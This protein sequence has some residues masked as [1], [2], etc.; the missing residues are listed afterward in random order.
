MAI[1]R[2][3]KRFFALISL[4]LLVLAANAL[5]YRSPLSSII[6]PAEAHWVVTGSLIDLVIVV[7]LLVLALSR[8]KKI[9]AR[10][11][12]PLM[13]AGMIFARFLIFEAYFAPFTY[14]P[15]AAI[16]IEA[17]I[18]L[19][20]LA[21]LALLI[22][23]LPSIIRIVRSASES[24][25]FSVQKGIET[26]IGNHM[27]LKVLASE[28]TM[29]YYS[30][31][32]W[33]KRP[34]EGEHVFSLHKK[35][36]MIAFY[37]ML[38]H[39]ILIETA[40][41]HWWLH[42]KSPIVSIVVLVLNIYSVFFFI[43]E[44][45]AVRLS[46]L[47]VKNRNLFLSLG[48]SKRMIIPLDEIKQIHWDKER[49]EQKIN[50]KE[51]IAFIAKDFMEEPPHCIIEFHES[52]PAVQFFGFERKFRMAAIRVDEPERFKAFMEKQ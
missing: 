15:W 8:K 48:L 26:N 25:L 14:L 40:G 45:Q 6:Q 49:V 52:L 12:I 20:E 2:Q 22:W 23:R 24:P 13:A 36:S 34:P 27:L 1:L 32:S 35:T 19:T 9:T 11:F 3:E 44:I 10:R 29:F 39:A 7:P 18:I 38:I 4:L 21:I 30:L 46:P 33:R 47:T 42:S 28:A 51:T 37:I 31:A 43:G 5:L 16:G 41:L 50:P 17:F